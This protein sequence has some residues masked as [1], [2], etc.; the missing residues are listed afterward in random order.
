MTGGALQASARPVR[1]KIEFLGDSITEGLYIW[2]TYNGQTTVPWRAD[3][4]RS[5]AS[6]TAQSLGAEWRQ[7]G[8]GGQGLLKGGSSGVPTGFL[9]HFGEGAVVVEC[10]KLSLKPWRER[11]QDALQ[12]CAEG[13]T[14]LV[15]EQ[16]GMGV[17]GT[18]SLER[19]AL[20]A[21]YRQL[22]T[23]QV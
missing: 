18:D 17:H 21:V 2:S 10:W 6:Q 1:P 3:A 16:D 20:R 19:S 14:E 12:T 9:Q 5:W 8:F 15:E 23:V 22:A 11:Q 7:V 13:L 4:R